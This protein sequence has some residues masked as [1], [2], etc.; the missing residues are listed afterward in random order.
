MRKWKAK[1]LIIA[2]RTREKRDNR[3]KEER[4]G[5]SWYEKRMHCRPL[6][7]IYLRKIPSLIT[8]ILTT[9]DL[10]RKNQEEGENSSSM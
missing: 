10:V 9:R 3:E 4:R 6:C 2:R 8:E 7:Y 1:D 5:A